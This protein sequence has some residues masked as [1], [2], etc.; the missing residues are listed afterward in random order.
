MQ[1]QIYR[2]SVALGPN[3]LS[4]GTLLEQEHCVHPQDPTHIRNSFMLYIYQDLEQVLFLYLQQNL[5]PNPY[6][7]LIRIHRPIF[8]RTRILASKMS[9]ALTLPR[10]S[11]HFDSTPHTL[12]PSVRNRQAHFSGSESKVDVQGLSIVATKRCRYREW[13]CSY[14]CTIDKA[15]CCTVASVRRCNA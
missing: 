4:T 2:W 9:L 7:S 8:T 10:S 3:R 5:D 12:Q 13:A 11:T 6:C 14:Q 15:P 1:R